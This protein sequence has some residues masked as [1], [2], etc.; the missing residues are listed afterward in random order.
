M[1]IQNTNHESKYFIPIHIMSFTDATIYS[2]LKDI[3]PTIIISIDDPGFPQTPFDIDNSNIIGILKLWFCDVGEDNE[4]IGI[5]ESDAESIVSFVRHYLPL[6]PEIM[7]HCAAGKSRSAG[8]AAALNRWLNGSDSPVMDSHY[9]TPNFLCYKRICDAAKISDFNEEKERIRFKQH[10]EEY[11][12]W[13]ENGY[14][15]ALCSLDNSLTSGLNYLNPDECYKNEK[16]WSDNESFFEQYKRL[17]IC[18]DNP[19]PED[20]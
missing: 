19:T 11:I 17:K 2:C 9:K 18:T 20:N 8:I 7:V 15:N 4:A 12:H 1:K 10:D 13:Y 5:T 16:G 14:D 6:R 3:P